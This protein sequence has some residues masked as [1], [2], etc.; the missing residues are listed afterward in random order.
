[1]FYVA[2]SKARRFLVS[3][4]WCLPL[5]LS[6][7]ASS[8]LIVCQRA[9]ICQIGGLLVERVNELKSGLRP[10]KLIQEVVGVVVGRNVA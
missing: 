6:W 5:D 9:M 8:V 2:V 7:Q 3:S 4:L 10:L 1:M